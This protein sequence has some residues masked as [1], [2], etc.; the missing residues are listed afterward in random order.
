MSDLN[1]IKSELGENPEEA[2]LEQVKGKISS[3][4]TQRATHKRKITVYINKLAELNES[5]VLT[6]TLCKKRLGEIQIE[7]QRVVEYDEIINQ[8]MNITDLENR[9]SAYYNNELDYQANYNINLD[10]NLDEYE[11]FLVESNDKEGS[12][13]VSTKV[14]TDLLSDGKPPPLTCGTFNGKEKDKFAFPNFIQQFENVIGSKKHLS[15]SAK[16]PYLLGYL[17]VMLSS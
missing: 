2:S 6:K 11:D 12:I 15:D 13:A 4:R 5:G 9:D 7:K 14:L 16:F 3:V 8:V 10:L 1:S 17:R